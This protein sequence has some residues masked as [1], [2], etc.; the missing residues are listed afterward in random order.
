MSLEQYKDEEQIDLKPP[1]LGIQIDENSAISAFEAIVNRANHTLKKVQRPTLKF[2]EYEK[3]KEKINKLSLDSTDAHEIAV[4]AN[5]WYDFMAEMKAIATKEYLDLDAEKKR[6]HAEA[7]SKSNMSSKAACDAVA[8]TLPIVISAR[9]HRNI[10]ETLKE[11]LDSE[12]KYLEKASYLAK[13]TWE[14]SE[15]N[16]AAQKYAENQK[17]SY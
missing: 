17:N 12:I 3:L 5:A 7:S 10:M 1:K 6:I 11:M 15:K 14:W 4:L 8:D 13:A 2:G 16:K 9:K